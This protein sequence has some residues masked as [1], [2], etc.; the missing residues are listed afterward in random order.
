MNKVQ[1]TDQEWKKQLTPAQYNITRKG[2][3]ERPYSGR[4]YNFKE[5]GIYRCVCCGNNLFN[6]DAKFNFRIG[7]PSFWTPCKEQN[8]CLRSERFLFIKKTEVICASCDAHLGYVFNDGPTPTGT[9]YCIN[10]KA[11]DFFNTNSDSL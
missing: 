3:T 11:L 8:V 7:W 10:S 9:R 1:K 4:Y 6:S 2:G 5:K